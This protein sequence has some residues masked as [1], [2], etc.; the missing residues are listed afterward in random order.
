MPYAS[1]K[2]CK[3]FACPRATR[4]PTGYCDVHADEYVPYVP[5]KDPVKERE[6]LRRKER[7]PFYGTKRWQTTRDKYISDNPLCEACGGLG[8]EVD[9]IVELLDGG[10]EVAIGN[11]QTMCKRC[12][13]KKTYQERLRRANEK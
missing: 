10:D 4:N 6:R 13:G 2:P 8:Q 5:T 12:H 3:S 1:K 7:N 11:L 9:H